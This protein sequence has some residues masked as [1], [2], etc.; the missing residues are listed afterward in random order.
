MG[1]DHGEKTNEVRQTQ[2]AGK[3]RGF[4]KSSEY[5]IETRS[6]FRSLPDARQKLFA[7]LF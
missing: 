2:Q 5:S 6:C 1:Q 7:V 3:V 4:E